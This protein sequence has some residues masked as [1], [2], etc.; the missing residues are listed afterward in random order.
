M[1]FSDLIGL[2]VLLFIALCGLY[3]LYRISTPI[4]Y[5]KEEYEKRLSKGS[6]IARGAMNA[7]MYPIEELLHP[8]AV[9]AIHVIKDVNQGHYDVLQ[10]S[11][12]GETIICVS[13]TVPGK[14]RRAV[15]HAVARTLS[16]VCFAASQTFFVNAA[17]PI[18]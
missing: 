1:D 16:A 9:E 7:L 8:K 13:H 15:R 11:G 18:F 17:D 5:T 6:G 3:G 12:D 14:L 4:N 2:F 10:E